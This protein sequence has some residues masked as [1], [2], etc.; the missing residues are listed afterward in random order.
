MP[1]SEKANLT[2]GLASRVAESI[3]EKTI[4]FY[5]GMDLMD[6]AANA[7]KM[8]FPINA[9]GEKQLRIFY[10]LA[11]KGVT[12]PAVLQVTQQQLLVNGETVTL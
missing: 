5:P 3:T 2:T 8:L 11:K 10:A 7:V 6:C 1:A 9:Q 4:T 12:A